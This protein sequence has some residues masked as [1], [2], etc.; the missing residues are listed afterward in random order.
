MK[1]IILFVLFLVFASTAH[2]FAQDYTREGKTFTATK[3]AS[4]AKSS[5]V[6]TSFI[7]VDTDGKSYT[8]WLSKNGHAF[9]KRVSKSG[10]SYN[11][12]LSEELSRE[13]CKEMGVNYVP[14]KP[15]SK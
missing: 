1:K 10:K 15:K 8:I 6:E 14:S 7:Y 5:S 13:V 11:K 4:G 12:Y 2:T 9:I 3:S